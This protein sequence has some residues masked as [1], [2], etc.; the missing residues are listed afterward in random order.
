MTDVL[1][2]ESKVLTKRVNLKTLV[3]KKNSDKCDVYLIFLQ[4]IALSL[5]SKEMR[6]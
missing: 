5:K 4:I 2:G 3:T 1:A 6:E